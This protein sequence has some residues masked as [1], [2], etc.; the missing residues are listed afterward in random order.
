M[1]DSENM[2][3]ILV[4][5]FN[6]VL[7]IEENSLITNEFSDISLNDMHII[8]AVGIAQ[9]KS[10]SSISKQLG[11]TMGTLTI[12]INGLVKKGYVLRNRGEKDRR[13]VYATLT[14]RGREAFEHHQQFHQRMVNAMIEHLEP[15]ETKRLLETFDK[16]E[17]FLIQ[18]D[19]N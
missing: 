8:E 10:M 16:L 19:H 2:N 9:Q 18:L 3:R 7:S 14:Q 17:D 4:K 11:V 13:V 12:G 5:L 6:H 15:S 1:N